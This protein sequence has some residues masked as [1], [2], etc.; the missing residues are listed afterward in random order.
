M[1]P[2]HKF[3]GG[4]G[5]TLCHKCSK[6]INEGLT[7]DLYCEECGGIKYKY[8]LVRERDGL[9]KKGNTVMWIEWNEDN[10]Y[11]KSH[12]EINTGYSLILDPSINYTWL[13]TTVD[14]ILIRQDNYIKFKTKNSIYELFTN[15]NK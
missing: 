7:Q 4:R 11:S 8:K 10:S 5:A 6:I 1:K 2:I 14:E 15:E 9:I 12:Q 3:N 13:T